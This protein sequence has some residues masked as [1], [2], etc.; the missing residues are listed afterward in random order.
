MNWRHSS[1]TVVA[2]DYPRCVPVDPSE[3]L[4][5]LETTLTSIEAVLDLPR[6]NEDLAELEQQAADPELWTDQERA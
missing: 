3:A 5:A 4:K 1:V 6:M 2:T